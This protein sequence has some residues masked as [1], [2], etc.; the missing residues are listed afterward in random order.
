MDSKFEWRG[1]TEEEEEEEEEKGMRRSRGISILVECAQQLCSKLFQL[2]WILIWN[3]GYCLLHNNVAVKPVQGE[4]TPLVKDYVAL[5]GIEV[6]S[7][8]RNLYIL[9][10]QYVKYLK[11]VS[12]EMLFI[13]RLH[14]WHACALAYI[15]VG[16][17][18][19]IRIIGEGASVKMQS[20]M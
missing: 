16:E 14:M 8:W 12:F 2:K 18:M 4:R 13:W 19:A 15:A 10:M 3:T 5:I 6:V 1:R 11:L 7:L 9:T 20:Y 17:C